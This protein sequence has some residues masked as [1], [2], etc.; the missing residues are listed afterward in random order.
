MWDI[1]N[2]AALYNVYVNLLQ[3]EPPN[4]E[5]FGD[6]VARL[7]ESQEH[8]RDGA[9]L[10]R[11]QNALADGRLSYDTVIDSV[12]FSPDGATS[13]VFT[14]PDGQT[15]VV[16]RGTGNGEWIDN[17]TGLSGIAEDNTYVTYDRHGRPLS[18]VT[19]TD[20]FATDQQVA[21]LNEFYRIAA[22]K[23][24]NGTRRI[25]LSGHSKGGNKAMFIALHTALIEACFSFNG[26]GFSPEALQQLQENAGVHWEERRARLFSICADND[27]V[28]AL[29]KQPMPQENI[30]FLKSVGG[31]HTLESIL[32][33]RGRLRPRTAQGRVAQYV[34][35]VSDT[36]M[37]MPPATRQY[38]TRGVMN[39]FQRYVG[40]GEPT[41]GDHVS[42]SDTA[43][44]L[45]VAL[46]AVLRTF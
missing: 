45:L 35:S 37:R 31:W 6:A 30:V 3:D 19:V 26:Q 12:S 20:D 22:E 8:P 21:A 44:G 4:A 5:R 2:H 10:L 32:D 7:Q 43:A 33:M 39:V 28:S 16:F 34:Q 11:L 9:L 18:R 13:A 41:N 46:E 17:G 1:T 14:E 15:H 29:G 25:F 36:L 24:W 23:R 38:A 27:Y 42:H 40:K